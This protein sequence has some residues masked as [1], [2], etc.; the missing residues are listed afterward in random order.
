MDEDEGRGTQ[1]GGAVCYSILGPDTG[2]VV[3]VGWC[4]GGGGQECDSLVTSDFA[5]SLRF[6]SNEPTYPH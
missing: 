1:A 3:V 6:L 4:S 5:T 2:L